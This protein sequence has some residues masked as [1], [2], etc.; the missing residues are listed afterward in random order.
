MLAWTYY[1]IP[2]SPTV[3][4]VCLLIYQSQP[5]CAGIK[6]FRIKLYKASLLQPSLI[7]PPL[8]NSKHSKTHGETSV[9]CIK[10]M[11]IT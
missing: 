9:V 6:Q 1:Y 10:V 3:E 7:L 2:E 5:I 11:I 4:A 8:I